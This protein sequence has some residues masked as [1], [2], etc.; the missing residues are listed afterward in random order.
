VI[1]LVLE[2]DEGEGASD[3]ERAAAA[4]LLRGS[5]ATTGLPA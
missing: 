5:G 2:L 4:R 3:A 1:T